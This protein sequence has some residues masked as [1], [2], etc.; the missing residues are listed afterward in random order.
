MKKLL[1]AAFLAA[2]ALPADP[3]AGAPAKA[4]SYIEAMYS[5]QQ[6]MNESQVIAEGVIDKSDAKTKTCVVKVT[7]SLKGKCAYPEIRINVGAGQAWHPDAVMKHL[8]VGAPALFFTNGQGQCEI[9][10]N[11]FFNQL[12]ADGQPPDKAWFTFTHIEIRCNRTFNGTAEELIKLVGDVLAGKAKPPAPEP[13][14]PPISPQDVAALPVWGQKVEADQLP[15]PFRKREPTHLTKPRDA[16]NPANAVPGLAYE[17]YEGTWNELP[18]FDKLTPA[19][20][21]TTAAFDLSPCKRQEQI[22]LRLRGFLQVPKDGVYTFYTVSDDGS[23]LYIGK[24]EVVSNDGLHAPQEM[25][26]DIHLKA[27][28]HAITVTFFENSGG[29]VLDVLWE[30]PDL[31][32]Q[33]IPPAALFRAP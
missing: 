29:E 26:G 20:K 12:Y 17:Y 25:V 19:A 10:I 5:L 4:G 27:G 9:Y 2:S 8:V 31:P 6:F 15:V 22:G 7:R 3:T 33:K 21:G 14:I 28:K 1:A 30:G 32:K 13:R 18:D 23:K 11:R 16:E 24:T